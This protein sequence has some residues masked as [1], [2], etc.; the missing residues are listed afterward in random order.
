MTEHTNAP[1]DD[2]Q[3]EIRDFRAGLRSAVLATVGADGAPLASYAPYITDEAGNF[4]VFVS[5]LS[6]HTHDLLV[7][8]LLPNPSG[9]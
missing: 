7:R 6:R 4:Y 9:R 2:L 5:A 3:R 8:G 1:Q